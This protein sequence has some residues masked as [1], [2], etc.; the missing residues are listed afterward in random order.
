MANFR[1]TGT[2]TLS[3]SANQTVMMLLG[4]SASVRAHLHEIN[5][6]SATAATPGADGAEVALRQAT[7]AG[8]TPTTAFTPLNTNPPGAA[9][10]ATCGI[11]PW[12][13]DPTTA[14]SGNMLRIP[15]RHE[16]PWRWLA[17]PGR[18]IIST[19]TANNGL[20]LVTVS[21]A[22]TAFA[23]LGSLAWME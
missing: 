13:T 12:T 5:L 20:A 18:E 23:A 16:I 1:G 8:T 6:G 9:A 7:T 2:Q 3:V 22:G 21:I 19:P 15:L 4:G 14:A 11:G 17:Y 10:V